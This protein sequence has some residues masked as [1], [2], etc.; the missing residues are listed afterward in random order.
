[1][2]CVTEGTTDMDQEPHSTSREASKKDG[3]AA[4]AITLLAA[5]LIAV[6]ISQIV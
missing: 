3:L 2:S 1:M 4:V 6:L 5:V